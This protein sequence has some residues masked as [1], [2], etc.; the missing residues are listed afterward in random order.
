M[1]LFKSLII[2]EEQAYLPAIY[3]TDKDF[4]L[5][6]KFLIYSSNSFT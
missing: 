3:S 2:D 5:I 4:Q 6:E 1:I